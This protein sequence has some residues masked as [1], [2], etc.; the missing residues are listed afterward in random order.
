MAGP[1]AAHPHGGTAFGR[2]ILLATKLYLPLLQPG[3]LGPPAA[4]RGTR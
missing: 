1:P 4:D 3:F 2:D